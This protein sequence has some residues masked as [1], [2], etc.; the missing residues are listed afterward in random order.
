MWLKQQV[1]Q[2]F[3]WRTRYRAVAHVLDCWRDVGEWW[4]DDPELWFWRV[5]TRDQG[6]YELAWDPG[7]NR[8]WVYRVYD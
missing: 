7:S 3:V 1:P 8:W 2:A 5:Q 6:I 4:K